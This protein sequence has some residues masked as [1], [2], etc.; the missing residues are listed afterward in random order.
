MYLTSYSDFKTAG[1]AYTSHFSKLRAAGGK[2]SCGLG[3]L[4][5]LQGNVEEMRR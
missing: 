4:M 2:D 5:V 3:R 1:V